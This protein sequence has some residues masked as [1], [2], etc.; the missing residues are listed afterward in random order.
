MSCPRMHIGMDAWNNATGRTNFDKNN[1][2]FCELQSPFSIFNFDS[3]WLTYERTTSLREGRT[4]FRR[5]AHVIFLSL[6]N[7]SFSTAWDCSVLFR[8]HG[9][10]PLAEFS[11]LRG[12]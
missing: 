3:D 9:E 4:H 11:C 6:F 7:S 1:P 12:G 5:Y 10:R 8:L 2:H